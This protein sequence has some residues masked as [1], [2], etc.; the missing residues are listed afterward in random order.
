MS[1]SPVKA[2]S[3][4]IKQAG[5]TKPVPHPC[6]ESISVLAEATNFQNPSPFALR[7]TSSSAK[8]KKLQLSE[9]KKAKLRK[10]MVT[11]KCESP[12]KPNAPKDCIAQAHEGD[13]TTF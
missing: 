12:T 8:R 7:V 9:Q 11:G 5:S 1:T 13:E 6:E 10:Y 4:P 3:T 2:F